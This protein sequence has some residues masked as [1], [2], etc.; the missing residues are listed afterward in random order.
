MT[1]GAIYWVQGDIIL[2]H[3]HRRIAPAVM[4]HASALLG[5]FFAVKA[6]SYA[7]DRYLLLYG[8]N[9]VVVGAGYTDIH[10]ELP[11]IYALIVLA[12]IGAALSFANIWRRGWKLPSA[13]LVLVFGFSFL[14]GELFPALF[15]RLY[16]KPN[17]L[18]LEAP[19][20][21]Q[22]IALT[23]EAFNLRQIAVKPFPA[24]AGL[25]FQSL[26]ENSP[27]IDNI[28]LWDWQPLMDTY[29]QLQEIRTYYKFRDVN[30][31]RYELGGAY[32]QVNLAARELEP[33]L[34]PANAQTWVNQHVI[35]THGN[36]VV[37]SP[38]TPRSPRKGCRCSIC[39]TSRRSRRAV[40]KSKSR[41][42]ITGRQT[43]AMYSSRHRPRNSIIRRARTMS[44]RA[45][46]AKVA[47]L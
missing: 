25:T 34:L 10:I 4:G 5:L 45:L 32:Q 37:M 33:S 35:F 17:E 15:Q 46:T 9:G 13:S 7:L 16:V 38:V 44:M 26:R 19:Y 3:G 22:N 31:D 20:I 42:S 1:A 39:R 18:Q 27:T 41:A 14:A 23:K 36:G 2:E 11:V 28:K 8:D 12:V 40:L 29:A 30:V 43:R 47:F 21:Q 6:W 24:E